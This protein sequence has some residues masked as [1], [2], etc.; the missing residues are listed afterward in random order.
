ML[1]FRRTGDIDISVFGVEEW[2]LIGDTDPFTLCGPARVGGV[3]ESSGVMDTG[4]PL[5]VLLATPLPFVMPLDGCDCHDVPRGSWGG[6]ESTADCGRDGTV[7]GE[8]GERLPADSVPPRLS[9]VSL[10]LIC[11]VFRMYLFRRPS[12]ALPKNFLNRPSVGEDTFFC[13]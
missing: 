1:E 11:Y 12:R 9:L 13:G 3:V 5:V 4:V 7:P 2:S 6:L 8:E 10:C